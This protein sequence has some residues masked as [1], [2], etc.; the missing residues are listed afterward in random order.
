MKT[1]KLGT[2][3]L[4]IH[5][6]Q[7][8]DPSYGAI[9]PP[10]YQTSTYVMEDAGVHKGYDYARCGNPARTALQDNL[11]ALEHAKYGF[12]YASGTAANANIM[13]LLKA[14]DHVLSVD[15][16]YGGTYRLFE[17][18]YK[19]FGITYSLVD[20][21]DEQALK[22]AIRP[23]TKMLWIE[24]PTNPQLKI[25]DI[26]ACVEACAGQDIIS[27]VDNTFA[28]PVI[29]N[30]LDLGADIV[31]HST[32][33]FI[34]GHSDLLGGFLACNDD[35]IGEQLKFYQN[36]LG[37]VPAPFDVFLTLR[38]VKTLPL[39][40]E[41]A[42]S[43]AQKLAEFLSERSD[44]VRL[45]YPGLSSDAGYE[46]AKRQ[47]SSG[48][49]MIT[50]ELEGGIER[51]RRFLKAFEIFSLAE[52][53]GGVESLVEHPAIMTHAAIPKEKREEIGI[54]DGLVRLSVG[55]ETYEDLEADL[56]KALE[57]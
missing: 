9:V 53:L 14:G 24:T 26:K 43:N 45:S 55:I 32:T 18:C 30:P 22:A 25:F 5:A 34:G 10:I 15:D 57:A 21:N 6:G 13:H 50:M 44:L 35:Q 12:C 46:V 7:T 2:E 51:A 54:N 19:Q 27:V 39:R 8:P 29:Q 38:S 41:R 31:L 37:A 28:S 16:L 17:Q 40:V 47:M 48:G 49:A 33:K 4:A 23:E 20:F 52:S 3:T 56:F 1:K 42:S 36:A 11:A